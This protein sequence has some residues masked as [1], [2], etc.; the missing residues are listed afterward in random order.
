M[1][2]E[3]LICY[4]NRGKHLVSDCFYAIQ[5]NCKHSVQ[6]IYIDN[7]DEVITVII[8][9]GNQVDSVN[10]TMQHAQEIGFINLDALKNYCK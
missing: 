6:S 8:Q 2:N 3:T 7:F 1:A 10:I 9:K 5:R 4:K